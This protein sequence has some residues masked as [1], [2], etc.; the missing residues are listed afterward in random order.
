LF[1]CFPFM[2]IG[3]L[4]ANHKYS[5]YS[6]SKWL[7]ILSLILVL[8][9][10]YIIFR[11]LSNGGLVSFDLL[12]SSLL[13]SPLIFLYVKNRQINGNTREIA[14]FSTAIY[15]IHPIVLHHIGILNIEGLSSLMQK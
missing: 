1:F 10:S 11:I 6:P 12:L 5:N 9:E 13:A 15:L 8:V 3:Y 14:I 4:L 2:A 7:V